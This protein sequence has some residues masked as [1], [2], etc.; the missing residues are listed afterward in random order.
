MGAFQWLLVLLSE[1]VA[2]AEWL[3][4]ECEPSSGC[5]FSCW[6]V[7]QLLISACGRADVLGSSNNIGAYA[8]LSRHLQTISAQKASSSALPRRHSCGSVHNCC[9][10][11][12]QECSA[13]H[14]LWS[15]YA[16][17][18]TSSPGEIHVP[19]PVEVCL[20][21]NIATQYPGGLRTRPIRTLGAKQHD[22]Y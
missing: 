20:G 2:V 4:S 22:Q 7:W 14:Q 15:P 11:I 16:L 3:R 1:C 5:L 8:S 6:S 17:V 18:Q 10:V 12:I 13:S 19:M 9:A 21:P